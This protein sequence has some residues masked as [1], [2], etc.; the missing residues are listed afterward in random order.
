MQK[1][2]GKMPDSAQRRH[3]LESFLQSR[4]RPQTGEAGIHA[5]ILN[6]IA[7]VNLRGNPN[8]SQFS[9]TVENALGQPL[10]LESN[11][12]STGQHR[13]YWLGPDEWLIVSTA[14]DAFDL[15]GVLQ[16]GLREVHASVNDISG[17]QVT[18]RL[19][20]NNVRNVLSK[21][22]PIDFHADTFK[23]GDCAQSGL[24]KAN[25]LIGYI[26][27]SKTFELIVRRSFAEYLALWLQHAAHDCGIEF[28]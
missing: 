2:S 6:D 23:P 28:R 15:A 19:K 9:S 21:G 26:E 4:Q 20:G 1:E 7:H 17:G 25:V 11:T 24:A 3:G 10:P 12:V 8:D 13:V 22:C 27:S 18:L 16:T 14:T 5:Q